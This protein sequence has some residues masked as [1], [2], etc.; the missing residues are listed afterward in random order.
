MV[1]LVVQALAATLCLAQQG[2]VT[3]AILEGAR[4]CVARAPRYDGRYVR[5]A[6]PGGDPGWEIGVCTDV[7]IRSFRRAGID[8]Q[9]LVH[10]DI[11]RAP[12]A[13]GIHRPD[14][15]IDHRRVRN[16]L[17]FFRRH[18]RSLP[19][20]GEWRPGDVVVWSLSGSGRPDH[21]GL[22]A[23]G[24]GPSGDPLVFHHFPRTALFSGHPEVSDCLHLWRILGH[25]R[26]TGPEPAPVPRGTAPATPGPPVHRP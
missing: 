26:W 2:G 25:F 16:L 13:Y 15:S 3:R 19:V 5:L 4:E 8:L 24:T 11:L 12:A 1:S 7:V 10:Q 18:A 23:E 6:Y 9:R 20:D 22:V 14:P 17:V 21:I